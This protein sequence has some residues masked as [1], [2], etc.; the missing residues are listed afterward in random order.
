MTK[1]LLHLFRSYP[2]TLLCVAAIWYMS[3]FKPPSTRLSEI[4]GF[5]KWV[6]ALMYAG[7]C[8]LMWYERLR[9]HRE[10][11]AWSH[12]LSIGLFV[13]LFMSGLLELLQEYC[14]TTRSGEWADLCA[15][16]AG[17]LAAALAAL[18]CQK[19]RTGR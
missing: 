14:T 5:D 1:Y 7:L 10:P 13:P 6:H 17:I 2:L 9:H 12:F 16:A 8:S 3:L 15:N 11:R 4:E 19:C 18:V